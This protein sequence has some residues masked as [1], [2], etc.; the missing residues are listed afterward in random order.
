MK[1]EATNEC[2]KCHSKL[3]PGAMFCTKCGSKQVAAEA[4]KPVEKPADPE[5]P[6]EEKTGSSGSGRTPSSPAPAPASPAPS[7]NVCFSCNSPL[8]PNGVFCTKCGSKQP[9]ATADASKAAPAKP[10]ATDASPRK[11]PSTDAVAPSPKVSR[12]ESVPP[13]VSATPVKPVRADSNPTAVAKDVSPAKIPAKSGPSSP[14]P[15]KKQP[16]VVEA[17][18]KKPEPVAVEPPPAVV[19]V[20]EETVPGRRMRGESFRRAPSQGSSIVATPVPGTAAPA[21]SGDTQSTSPPADMRRQRS[22]SLRRSG[23]TPA[24][25]LTENQVAEDRRARKGSFRESAVIPSGS[26]RESVHMSPAEREAAMAK[27]QA[28]LGSAAPTVVKIQCI[29][30]SRVKKTLE[31]EAVDGIINGRSI[32]SA[33]NLSPEQELH[34]SFVG[35]RAPNGEEIPFE[36][37]EE[38]PW[39]H[40]PFWEEVIFPHEVY[41]ILYEDDRDVDVDNLTDAEIASLEKQFDDMDM[42]KQGFLTRDGLKK[43]FTEQYFQLQRDREGSLEKIMSSGTLSRNRKPKVGTPVKMDAAGEEYVRNQVEHTMQMDVT[44]SGRVELH[45]YAR[46]VA[47]DIVMKRGNGRKSIRGN[48]MSQRMSGRKYE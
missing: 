4:P 12:S 21:D 43:Y 32:Q 10:S 39:P 26:Y 15:V 5:K 18:P 41:E 48:R 19:P 24:P 17:S 45:E 42:L 14:P 29:M 16:S 2:F 7:R 8:K 11:N 47:P 22:E 31:V 30:D 35:L 9:A 1:A 36:T 44:G 25:V 37:S 6:A 23:P 46:G 38:V 33:W 3:K 40:I 13:P 34:L 27:I 20:A 28:L